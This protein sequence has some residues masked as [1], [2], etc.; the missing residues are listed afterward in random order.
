MAL[1]IKP[2]KGARDFYPEDMRVRNAIFDVWRTVAQRYGYEEYDAP[3]LE[4]TELFAAKSGEELVNEQS[5]GFEDRGGRQVMIRPEMTPSVSRLVAGKRQELAQ[6][7]RWFSIPSCWRYE[8]PQKGRG[9]EFYQ[10]NLD[11]FGLDTMDAEVEMIQLVT[12]IMKGFHAS[13]D[14]YTIKVNDRRFMEYLLKDYIGLDEVE[15][16]TVTKLID[17]MHKIPGPEFLGLIEAAISPSLRDSG[18]AQ[19]LIDV[20][21]CKTADDLPEELRKHESYKDIFDIL[22]FCEELSIIN[23]EFDITLMRGLD[24]Y[25]GLVFEVFDNDPDNNRSM[26]GGGRYDGLV[27]LF[28]VDPIPTV[29]FAMSDVVLMEF[30]ESHNLIPRPATHTEVWLIPIAGD[31]NDIRKVAS[32]LRGMGVNV[33]VDWSDKKADKRIKNALKNAVPYVVFV[34]TKELESG[35]YTLKNLAKSEEATYSLERLVTVVKDHRSN[36]AASGD[37]LLALA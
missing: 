1:S 29:G 12:S 27:G 36:K 3:I 34:G 6:P 35:Q 33:A 11:I 18:G 25:T 26:F 30:L 14:M 20:L 23:V 24:Y 22:L 28:G 4:P 16:A 5:Y 21:K 31:K 7:I 2:Y 15:Q 8:R 19:K 9:R 17:K 13:P 10:L 32:D 37:D